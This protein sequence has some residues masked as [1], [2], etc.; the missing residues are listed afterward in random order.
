MPLRLAWYELEALLPVSKTFHRLILEAKPHLPDWDTMKNVLNSKNGFNYH[1]YC[2][3]RYDECSCDGTDGDEDYE[4]V[5]R[6]DPMMNSVYKSLSSFDQFK[7]LLFHQ[8]CI[9]NLLQ[10]YPEDLSEDTA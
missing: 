10:F 4:A 6:V 5:L 2:Q 1:T 9:K 8:N 7:Q 3:K